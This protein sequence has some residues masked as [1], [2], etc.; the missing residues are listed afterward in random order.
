MRSYRSAIPFSRALRAIAFPFFVSRSGVLGVGLLAAVFIGYDPA[1]NRPALWRIS[2]NPVHNLLARWDTFWYLDIATRGYHWN[3]NALEQQNVVFFPLLPALIRLLGAAV[4]DHMLLAGL[5]VSLTAF[6]IALA[7]IWRW[8]AEQKDEDVA[9]AAVALLCA[10]PFSV[11]FSAV[12]TESLFL[13]AA[14][15]AWCHLQR[16]EH[17]RAAL[18]GLGAGLVRPNGFLLAAPLAWLALGDAAPLSR[19]LAV[20]AAPVVGVLLYSAYLRVHVGS[21]SAWIAGQA[22]WPSMAPW[23]GPGAPEPGPPFPYEPSSILVHLG[24]AAALVLALVA[25]WP[26]GRTLGFAAALLI[27]LN[28]LLPAAR[29]GLQSLGRFTSVLFPIFIWLAEALP[30]R[31]RVLVL[32]FAA[33]QI[34]AAILFF[35]WRPLV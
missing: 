9:A 28:L 5:A 18:F 4:H 11:F 15:G 26:V 27:A 35:T 10:F 25:I 32:V 12:Y 21:A 19:R 29:H 17:A 6:P 2:A 7:Y 16:R 14:A 30:K 8:T 33:G 3:G 23:G 13:M 34:V 22:A 20:V 31:R 24:N 1:P